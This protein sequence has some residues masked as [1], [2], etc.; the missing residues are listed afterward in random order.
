MLQTCSHGQSRRWEY[1]VDNDDCLDDEMYR[2]HDTA[3]GS[4]LNFETNGKLRREPQTLRE[5]A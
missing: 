4:S 1:L 3:L 2:I 5:Q